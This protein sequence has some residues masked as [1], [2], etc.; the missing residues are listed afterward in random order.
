M[1]YNVYDIRSF[2]RRRAGRLVRRIITG[3]ISEFWPDAEGLRIMGYGYAVPFLRPYMQDA[4]R[5]IAMMPLHQAV[6][7]WPET[8]DN[9]VCTIEEGALPLESESVDRILVVHGFEYALSTSAMLQECWRVL[10]GSGRLLMVVPNRL[11]LWSRVDRTPFGH[12]TPFTHGQILHALQ[13]NFF[14]HER[15]SRALFMP[16]FRSFLVL[17]TAYMMES[18][19]KFIFPGLAGAHLVEASKQ[20]YAGIGAPAKARAKRVR[21]LVGDA[22]PT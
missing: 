9:L 10:K 15:S 2:Y 11:G 7:T 8:Q 3:H 1:T 13:Q 12:G 21:V 4:E 5:I 18:F 19:G 17:Q 6:H 16:P 14:A 20:V 22:V